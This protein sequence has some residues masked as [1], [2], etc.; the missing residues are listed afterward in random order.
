LA[1]CTLAKRPFGFPLFPTAAMAS[2]SPPEMNRP[3]NNRRQPH[4]Q[5]IPRTSATIAANLDPD[6]STMSAAVAPS[7]DPPVMV[8]VY[9]EL[10][11][12][13]GNVK[14]GEPAVLALRRLQ[15]EGLGGLYD[16]HDMG[17]IDVEEVTAEGGP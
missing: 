8:R 17:I 14:A 2:L 12:W 16:R 3:A 10:G 5:I 15:R 4:R 11:I 13:L 1:R 6:K 9:D 7:A